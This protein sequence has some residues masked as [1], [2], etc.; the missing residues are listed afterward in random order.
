MTSSIVLQHQSGLLLDAILTQS[1]VV[2]D[3]VPPPT[4]ERSGSFL[5][6]ALSRTGDVEIWCRMATARRQ[7][8]WTEALRRTKSG[9]A[10][11]WWEGGHCYTPTQ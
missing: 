3:L 9:S 8:L 10:R 2:F 1:L 5:E 6:E 11:V 7:T 4:E